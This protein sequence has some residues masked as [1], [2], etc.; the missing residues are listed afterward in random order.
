MT[1]L[2][3]RVIRRARPPGTRHLL[4][5]TSL[6]VAG[7]SE[8]V[9][10]MLGL[11]ALVRLAGAERSGTLI[12]AQALASVWFLLLDP[13][14]E[15]AAQRFVPIEQRRSG[16]GAALYARL[17]GWDVAIGAAASGAGLVLVLGARLLG[18]ATDDLALMLALAVVSGGAAASTGAAGAAFALTDRLRA[19]GVLRLRCTAVSVALALGGLLA[20]GPAGYLAGQAAGAIV[21]AAVLGRLSL[22]VVR[23]DMGTVAGTGP[24]AADVPMPA[25]LAGFTLKASASTSVAAASESGVLALAGLLGDPA[26]VTVL[27]LASAPG[28]LYT[29]LISPVASMLHPRLA[30]AATAGETAP[31][32]RDVLR[33][34]LLLGAAGAGALAVAVPVM[35]EALGL[36][37][38]AVYAQA[39]QT[40]LLLLAVACVKG[41]VSWSKVLPL[42][43]GRPAW[44]LTYLSVEGVSLLA[45]LFAADRLAPGALP[46]SV[47]FGWGSLALAVLGS[48]V[49]ITLMRGLT[50][51]DE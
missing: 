6:T 1:P 31:I 36:V 4:T 46:T 19:F 48:G 28:R 34:T 32:R 49:W 47:A 12:F 3:E 11:V 29:T 33:S 25:G 24:A 30:R 42:A 13:R 18:W 15:D 14:L 44:R 23:A 20:L 16:R 10:S 51:A 37:Y 21:T 2:L 17:L 43:L 8:A 35:G 40:A 22:R 27:K 9:L 50:A 41:G 38:G 7:Q 39:G 45:L 5:F 26:L